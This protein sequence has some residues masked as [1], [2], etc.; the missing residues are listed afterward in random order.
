MEKVTKGIRY[1]AI[2]ILLFQLHPTVYGEAI[3]GFLRYHGTWGMGNS[4]VYLKD[5][6]GNTIASTSTNP[7][8]HFNFGNVPDGTYIVTASTQ[9]DPGGIDLG[10][11]FLI[12]LYLNDLYTFDELQAL[13]ADV[14]GDGEITWDDYFDIVIGWF[15]YGTPFGAGEWVFE[16]I[17]VTTGG[18]EDITAKGQSTGDI[19]GGYNP[20]KDAIIESESYIDSHELSAFEEKNILIKVISEE[21]L[22]GFHLSLDLP[23]NIEIINITSDLDGLKFNCVE[24]SLRI[25]W[26]ENNISSR[27]L[28]KVID[29]ALQIS[30]VGDLTETS[31]FI[32]DWAT[33]FINAE[34]NITENIN[35]I[36]PVILY[37]PK[38]QT[39]STIKLYPNPVIENCNLEFSLSTSGMVILN[40][41]DMSGKPAGRY[42][43]SSN[44][45][46]PQVKELNFEALKSGIYNYSVIISDETN[47]SQ[48]TGSLIKK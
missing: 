26:M 31:Y 46:G 5:I 10:D 21:E 23:E 11:A 12:Q 24:R 15:N 36:L 33:H 16:E 19:G 4:T 40:L 3:N 18:R 35:L 47:T 17:M 42:E 29:I 28:D 22:R 13:A 7:A 30:I 25:T 6:S 48:K 1:L 27:N 37:T 8:G 9:L 43:I 34:G 38:E 44:S 32:S 14:D 2:I 20:D 41:Y 45:Q 39:Y